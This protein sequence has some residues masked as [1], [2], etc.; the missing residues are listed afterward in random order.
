MKDWIN[1]WIKEPYRA[2]RHAKIKNDL[3]T[4]QAA[5]CGYIETITLGNVVVIVNEE[6][7]INDQMFNFMLMGDMIFGP[8]VFT[9]Q[10]GDELD[11]C[12]LE[13]EEHFRLWLRAHS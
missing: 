10:D 8:A 2:P 6:G 3:E 5:V 13:D 1:V 9:G 12:P 7:K 11:D 4:L